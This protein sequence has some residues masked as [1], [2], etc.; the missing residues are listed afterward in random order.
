[1]GKTRVFQYVKRPLFRFGLLGWIAAAVLGAVIAWVTLDPNPQHTMLVAMDRIF[2]IKVVY[3]FVSSVMPFTWFAI[4]DTV[5]SVVVM[6]MVLVAMSI[7][8]RPIR[9][10]WVACVVV[11]GLGSPVVWTESS[12][13]LL[14]SGL[15]PPGS[16]GLS[17]D[18]A[19]SA[20]SIL[21]AGLV[22]YWTRSRLV[23]GLWFTAAWLTFVPDGYAGGFTIP[24]N[25]SRWS[26]YIEVRW[27]VWLA[28]TGGSVLVWAIVLRRRP[29]PSES[30]C[31][32]CGYELQG[33]TLDRCPECGTLSDHLAANRDVSVSPSTESVSS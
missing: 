25:S 19:A 32:E 24:G 21:A 3:W 4:W 16:Y 13:W 6:S 10:W 9:W 12:I 5:I 22:F 14:R 7:A 33:V 8:P 29:V 27:M 28:M 23:A 2:G 18:V 11:L 1:M 26:I 15:T 17:R 31:P 30:L 20:L